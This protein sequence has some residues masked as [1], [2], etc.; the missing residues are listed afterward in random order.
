MK[1]FDKFVAWLE[2]SLDKATK[3]HDAMEAIPFM[4]RTPKQSNQM[5]TNGGKMTILKN[6][7]DYVKKHP[8]LRG[9]TVRGS[10]V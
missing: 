6:T 10:V 3:I 5:L 2:K 1:D 9:L 8:K 4:D 7:L